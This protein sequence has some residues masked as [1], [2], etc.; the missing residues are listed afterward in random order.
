MKRHLPSPGWGV[1]V[2]VVG[3]ASQSAAPVSRPPATVDLPETEENRCVEVA[4][5]GETRSCKGNPE[6]LDELALRRV[7]Q[8]ED[9]A[10]A[11]T[12]LARIRAEPTAADGYLRLAELLMAH[13]RYDIAEKVLE[14]SLPL[15]PRAES[16]GVRNFLATILKDQKKFNEAAKR[17]EELLALEPSR[18]GLT[19]SLAMMYL[20]TTPTNR[21]RASELFRTYLSNECTD[22]DA[23]PPCEIAERV[24]DELREGCTDCLGVAP[25]S[26]GPTPAVHPPPSCAQIPGTVP[27]L[28][29][30]ELSDLPFTNDDGTYTVFGATHHLRL[31]ARNAEVT[32][33]PITVSGCITATNYEQA[34]ACAVHRTGV[35]DPANCEAPAPS[36][37]LADDCSGGVAVRVMGWASNWAQIFTMIEG[38]DQYGDEAVLEDE[39]FGHELPNPIPAVGSRVRAT[40]T[41]GHFYTRGSRGRAADPRYGILTASRIE[42]IQ[43]APKRAL[44]PGM[45]PR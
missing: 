12:F 34:P 11:S 16:G 21:D 20:R 31:Q 29:A 27:A 35:A 32:Q 24:L 4:R 14:A 5:D 28:P 44:L 17:L 3:C 6:C 37:H 41:Y 40:G 26:S 30:I 36:F 39:F 43:R 18:A 13:D 23:T 42:L 10:A 22:R 1:A 25:P 2:V 9:S 38:I 8:G 45:R 33:Q 19:F 7:K 15:V